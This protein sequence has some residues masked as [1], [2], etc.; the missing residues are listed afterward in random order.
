MPWVLAKLGLTKRSPAQ[1]QSLLLAAKEVE[2]Y[3]EKHLQHL[4]VRCA[5]RVLP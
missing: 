2:E 1:L 5:L 3:A 4:K